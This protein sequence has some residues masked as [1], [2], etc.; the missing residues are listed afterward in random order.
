MLEISGKG[1][2]LEGKDILEN[3]VFLFRRVGGGRSVRHKCNHLG[4]LSFRNVH[5]VLCPRRGHCDLFIHVSCLK[6]SSYTGER[7]KNCQC[8]FGR[9]W[10]R[11]RHLF[12][13]QCRTETRQSA[14]M[15]EKKDIRGNAFSCL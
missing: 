3:K 1:I 11:Q 9:G 14:S 15:G 4:Y 2:T 5:D 8:V 13:H 12:Y 7:H 6:G 10:P